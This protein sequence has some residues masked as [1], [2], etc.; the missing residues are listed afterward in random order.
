ME[1]PLARRAQLAVVAHIRHVYTNYDKL[2][3]VTSFQEARSA[4]EEPCLAMLVQWRGDDENG[5]TVLEDVFREVIVISDDEDEESDSLEESYPQEREASVEV[6]SSN[7]EEIQ[8]KP[9]NYSISSFDRGAI[10]DISE[11]EAPP[12]IRFIPQTPRKR[13]PAEKKRPDRRGFSRYQAWDRARDRYK[14][15]KYAPIAR[16]IENSTNNYPPARPAHDPL[17][18]AD[19]ARS[20]VNGYPP[21][22]E[23][24]PRAARPFE[25]AS[26]LRNLGHRS[27]V[28]HPGSVAGPPFHGPQVG[29][30]SNIQFTPV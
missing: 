14:D 17:I 8:T 22:R 7:A 5:A 28:Q 12:G 6:V 16:A 26:E 30:F 21:D 25:P 9:V 19:I 1:L 2:L 24:V 20:N 11:D 15:S 10:Q 4:V 18:E 29:Y 27:M 13:K 23:P 3:R